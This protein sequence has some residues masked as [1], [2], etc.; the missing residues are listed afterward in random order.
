MLA[1]SLIAG[2]VGFL[3]LSA[4]LQAQ[5]QEPADDPIVVTCSEVLNSM[6][7]D[8]EPIGVPFGCDCT[9]LSRA[10]IPSVIFGPGSIDQAHAAVEFV[11]LDQVEKAL[12]F[13]KQIILNFGNET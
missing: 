12:E 8:P 6:N 1:R 2:A 11:D 4:S 9:K 10:G 3:A 7:L 13:Y 5:E